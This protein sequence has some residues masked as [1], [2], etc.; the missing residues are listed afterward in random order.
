MAVDVVTEVT[1]SRPRQEVAEYAADPGNATAWYA[2]IK[3]VAWLTPRPLA[4][5]T[6]LSF[7]AQ[8]MGR[9]LAYTYEVRE[10][11]P[12]ERLV[13][14]TADGPFP[15]QTTYEWTDA[16]DGGTIMRLSNRGQPTGFGKVTAPML[17][18]AMTRANNKDLLA[19][20][21]TLESP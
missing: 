2:N 14:S 1:I 10:L 13:M 18:K 8:F 20:K 9:R 12:G 4:V 7:V 11:V 16:P 19:L 6:R 21:A 17:A 15:M 5:G 3:Q